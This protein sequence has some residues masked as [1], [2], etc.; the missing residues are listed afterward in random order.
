MESKGLKAVA[1]LGTSLTIDQL[2]IIW[3]LVNEPIL[4][5]DGDNAGINASI[6]L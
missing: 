2:R 1:P 4:L 3:K 5:M 6:E